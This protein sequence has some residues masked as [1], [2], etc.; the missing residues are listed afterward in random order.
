MIRVLIMIAVAGF[1]VAV[2]TLSAA[3]AIGGPEAFA[4]GGW[5]LAGHDWDKDWNKHWDHDWHEA[6]EDEGRPRGPQ[7][8]R[9]FTWSGDESLRV[10]VP[11][12]VRYVQAPGP[13]RLTIT[14][15][16]RALSRIDVDKGRIG[17]RGGGWRAG[18]VTIVLSAPNVRRFDL[19]GANTLTIEGYRQETLELDLSGAAK[20]TA[21][22]E[23]RQVRI[24]ISGAAEADLG[25]V[26]TREA[27]VEISGHGEATVAPTDRARLDIS[28]M[29]EITLLTRPAQL[30]TDIAGAGKIRQA[31]PAADER[32]DSAT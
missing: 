8:T 10:A 16:E 14:G 28:G 9:T 4:R 2:A 32:P 26:K 15:S 7:V 18:K 17:R 11:A 6:W 1:I 22:G 12:D 3:F 24:D 19:S 13:A 25:A 29:G 5:M 30:E 31:A 23:A 21:A 20:V 27:E